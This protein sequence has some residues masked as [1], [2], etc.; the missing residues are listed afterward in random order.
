MNETRP[1]VRRS[2]DLIRLTTSYFAER[3]VDSPRLNA[4]ILLAQALECSRVELYTRFEEDLPSAR[5]DAFRELVRRRGRREPLQHIT[6]RAAFRD[7]ELRCDGR[8]L[9]PRPETELVAE[10]AIAILRLAEA[11][12][13]ADIGVG[14]GCVAVSIAAALPN[15]RV[16]GVDISPEALGLARE[17]VEA[18]G[19]QDR[20]RLAR[21]DLFEPLL[22][23]GLAGQV[24]LIVSNPPYVK[25]GE[26]ATLAPEVRDHDPRVALDGG[27]DGLA[28]YRRLF[29]E[30]R[31]VGKPGSAM[32]V[33]LAEDGEAPV[34]GLAERAGWRDLEVRKDCAGIGR[35]L[36]AWR[37]D[38]I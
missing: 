8:A 29:D 4:E 22:A 33:E 26:I 11:P 28:F 10:E 24:D 5:V 16:V 38:P 37:R 13:A 30:G 12:L 36:T 9:A 3:G 27:P 15:A 35:V 31:R 1:C 25:T 19:L 34:G 20:V 7:L 14:G 6:G 18:H 2:L 21:G 32:V 23:E 17:N